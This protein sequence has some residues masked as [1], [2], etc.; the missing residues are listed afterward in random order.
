MNS[1]PSIP[2]SLE[3]LGIYE[4]DFGDFIFDYLADVDH[5]L[6]E[7]FCNKLSQL[8][9][10]MSEF[11]TQHFCKIVKKEHTEMIGLLCYGM[12][13]QSQITIYHLTVK[14][15]LKFSDTLKDVIALLFQRHCTVNKVSIALRYISVSASADKNADRSIDS[16]LKSDLKAFGFKTKS[17]HV[18]IAKRKTAYLTY[19]IQNSPTRKDH[20]AE[21][22]KFSLRI[23]LSRLRPAGKSAKS[24]PKPPEENPFLSV[25]VRSALLLALSSYTSLFERWR[26]T[27][28]FDK[29]LY[30]IKLEDLVAVKEA[31][32]KPDKQASRS[33]T[34]SDKKIS[35]VSSKTL[36]SKSHLI[37]SELAILHSAQQNRQPSPHS[38]DSS[39][40]PKSDM[41][42]T[43]LASQLT[44]GIRYCEHS[45]ISV[46]FNT[47]SQPLLRNYLHVRKVRS[48]DAESRDVQ[49]DRQEALQRALHRAHGR[50]R[51]QHLRHQ[52]LQDLQRSQQTPPKEA[53]LSNGHRALQRS[54]R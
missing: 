11:L 35:C 42:H 23:F 50:P 29:P 15:R 36:S 54:R 26:Q 3:P 10:S 34:L 19:Q 52:R 30:S 46:K 49:S 43:V 5:I 41:S 7:S 44:V 40:P 13:N 14:D 48:S 21:N 38:P 51:S 18:D 20:R 17:V 8:K 27:A 9:H 32:E 6:K 28:D 16:Q 33:F 53:A 45:S 1:D 37:D 22:I 12:Q 2:H 4:R 24:L 39:D 25:D 31:I 47:D